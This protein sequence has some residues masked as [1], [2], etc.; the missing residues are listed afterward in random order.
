LLPFIAF[1]VL[2]SESDATAF[3][4][5]VWYWAGSTIV[6]NH[7]RVSLPPLIPSCFWGS[8]A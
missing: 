2:L 6:P 8:E 4:T 3:T 7:T 5:G 1:F